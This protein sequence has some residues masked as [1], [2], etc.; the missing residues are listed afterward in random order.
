MYRKLRSIGKEL[1]QI[2]RIRRWSRKIHV[3]DAKE[4]TMNLN[5]YQSLAARTAAP[6]DNELVN[7]GL[8]IAGEAGEVADLIKKQFFMVIPLKMRKLKR[9]WGMYCG[10]WRTL[11][12]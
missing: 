11:L 4:K 3:M 5:D 10:I 7:Y 12:E 8:G 6:H 2:S 1:D 9:S